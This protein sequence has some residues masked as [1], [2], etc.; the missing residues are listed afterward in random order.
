M[1]T[2]GHQ[3]GALADEAGQLLD[4]VAARLDRMKAVR[5]EA[6]AEVGDGPT[7]PEPPAAGTPPTEHACVGWCP[8]CRGAELLRGDRT[9]ISDRLLDTAILVVSTLRSLVPD[10][11]TTPSASPDQ[12]GPASPGVE[13][14]DIR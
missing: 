11:S 9:E 8:I 14:I 4:A 6:G 2:P 13:R 10:P 1:T 5:V 12:S 7:A 3:V